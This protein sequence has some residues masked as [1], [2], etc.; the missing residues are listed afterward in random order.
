MIP[1][2]K[3]K[4]YCF[5][6]TALK[7]I[8]SEIRDKGVKLSCT[9]MSYYGESTAVVG[10]SCANRDEIG[11]S[12]NRDWFKDHGYRKVTPAQ[13]KKIW[14]DQDTEITYKNAYVKKC[15]RD[16][17]IDIE[18]RGL[19]KLNIPSGISSTFVGFSNLTKGDIP[20][21]GWTETEDYWIDC[22]YYEVTPDE[23]LELWTGTNH[24]IDQ[25]TPFNIY[26][27]GSIWTRKVLQRLAKEGYIV[28]SCDNDFKTCLD[29]DNCIFI[30]E[31]EGQKVAIRTTYENITKKNFQHTSSL[32]FYQ[33]ISGKFWVDEEPE[34][35]EINFKDYT[36]T[37][38]PCYK[39]NVSNFKK[40]S[41]KVEEIVI[42]IN[43]TNKFKIII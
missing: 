25:L 8:L 26:T 6:S 42:N 24:K 43:K 15:P 23:F 3:H 11:Y 22:G 12:F 28:P 19:A 17:L 18:K 33:I 31:R 27:V 21:I 2:D 20:T 10:Y 34:N 14:F 36:D 9:S 38:K 7:N 39:E 1:L 13:F 29:S 30:Q 35:I 4:I 5:G 40:S 41:F 16:I 37:E 32:Q